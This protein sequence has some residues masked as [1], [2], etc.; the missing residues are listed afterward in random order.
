MKLKILFTL[1]KK[2]KIVDMQL[3]ASFKYQLRTGCMLVCPIRDRVGVDS[4]PLYHF[5]V[6][7]ANCVVETISIISIC[8]P[9]YTVK[10]T[11]P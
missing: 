9:E 6:I 11:L 8:H 1:R 5:F 3:G 7:A 2:N 10:K 4:D